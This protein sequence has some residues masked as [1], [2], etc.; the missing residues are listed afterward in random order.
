MIRD[1]FSNMHLIKSTS[2]FHSEGE[3][4]LSTIPV[5]FSFYSP[6][7]PSEPPPGRNLP[8]EIKLLIWLFF[9]RS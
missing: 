9:L 3:Q 4:N 8:G 6:H 2:G 7:Y 5:S 1:P